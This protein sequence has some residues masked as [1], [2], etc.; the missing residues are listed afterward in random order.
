MRRLSEFNKVYQIQVVA[1]SRVVQQ[2]ARRRLGRAAAR[3]PAAMATIGD[4]RAEAEV[5]LK[6]NN[7]KQLFRDLGTKLMFERPTDPNACGRP[8][9][10][11]RGTR[12]SL[13]PSPRAGSC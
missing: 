7:V 11:C 1:L 9:G 12:G 3:R 5:Y 8:R 4:P 6:Q 13:T 10:A 2:A